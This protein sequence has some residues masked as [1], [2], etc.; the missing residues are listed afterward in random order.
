MAIGAEAVQPDHRPLRRGAGFLFHRLQHDAAPSS[1]SRIMPLARGDQ[2]SGGCSAAS[3][4]S[5][6]ARTSTGGGMFSSGISSRPRRCRKAPGP[7]EEVSATTG[8]ASP[9]P[10][11]TGAIHAAS[12]GDT[13]QASTPMKAPNTPRPP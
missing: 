5:C 12:D 8:T 7:R 9:M 2:Y 11:T 10:I 4:R 6:A 13:A 3:R 1:S